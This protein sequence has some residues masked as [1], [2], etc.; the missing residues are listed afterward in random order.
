M[1]TELRAD[2]WE[3]AGGVSAR[4]AAVDGAAYYPAA[5]LAERFAEAASGPDPA[6][7]IAALASA[8]E[9]FFAAVV[10]AAA[11]TYL[12]ADRARSIPLYYATD[13]RIVSDR[14]RLVR[15]ATD[16][17]ADPVAESEF[18]LTRYVTGP[19]TVW[20]GV[21][22][23]R[24]GEV[25]ALADGGV[26]R[27][28]Y[29]A[30]WPAGTDPPEDPLGTLRSGF[31]TALDRL[32]RVA[33][34]R[35]IVVPLSGGHDSR[36]LAAGLRAR[37]HEVVTFT[38]GRSGHP[39]VEVSR[40]VAARLGVRWEF[41]P[42]DAATWREA[43]HGADCERYRTWAFGGDALPF[44]AEWP[45]VHRLVATDR[46]PDDALFCPGHTVAT[47]SERL[48]VFVGEPPRGAGDV[49]SD[50]TER[51][52][53]ADL[54]AADEPIDPTIDALVD[55]ILERRYSLWD[56]DDDAFAAAARE[57]IRRG[58]LGC[59]DS[60]AVAD[61][62]TAAAAY[63]RWEWAGRMTT[64]TNGDL[65]VYEDAGLEWWLPLWDPAYV[66]AW[67]RLPLASRRNK[68]LHAALAAE[69]YRSAGDVTADRAGVTDRSLSALDRHLS[70][71]RHT[72]AR[73]FT[74]RGGDW[75]PPF[76]A[77]RSAWTEPGSHPLAWDGAVL[78]ELLEAFEE[79]PGFYPLR[80]LAATG[81]LDLADPTA[82]V[83][84]DGTIALPTEE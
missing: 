40:E 54:E 83:P 63:E 43:Y 15:E 59:R 28:R 17:D 36:L 64:F 20:A 12:V 6:E 5:A 70:L 33:D 16:A 82:A 19:E 22:A 53:R 14:G 72:P 65:R 45:A 25:V 55:R 41:V 21:A 7:S 67:E 51:A 69:Y 49:D 56:F 61:P 29:W 4:G 73:Q 18:L 57:R 48:P 74:E 26:R 77:P 27:D 60:D 32:E 13:G 62:E 75:A 11:A 37:G 34:G 71:V 78:P 38:F 31:E 52:D 81:R 50:Q 80:T 76:L 2:G 1:R 79:P 39:D 84:T 10:P 30:Y 24:P 3:T 8:L 42:Y 47:P 44:L 9:G 58:A 46:V 23:T 66:R 68:R 35:P